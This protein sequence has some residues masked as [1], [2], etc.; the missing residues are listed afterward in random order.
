MMQEIW[1]R[2]GREKG[3]INASSQPKRS[4]SDVFAQKWTVPSP[5]APRRS[6]K[7]ENTR[8]SIAED[9]TAAFE[10]PPSRRAW[11]CAGMSAVYLFV[12]R[13]KSAR[14]A[15]LTFRARSGRTRAKAKTSG[16]DKRRTNRGSVSSDSIRGGIRHFHFDGYFERQYPGVQVNI[17]ILIHEKWQSL[18]KFFLQLKNII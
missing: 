11:E 12:G 8:R 5:E 16:S 3:G 7:R 10:S 9:R 13:S 4:G 1:R 15:D 14:S 6:P 2:R 18:N 17:R